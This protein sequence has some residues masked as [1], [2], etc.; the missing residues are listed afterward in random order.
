MAE[1]CAPPRAELDLLSAES[2]RTVVR[3]FQPDWILH[4][5]AYTAVDR[6]EA[7]RDACFAINSGATRTFAEEA[8]RLDATLVTFSTD[9]VFDGTAD[10]AYREDDL[11]NPINVYGASKLQAEK[12]LQDVGCRYLNFR[13]SWVYSARGTNFVKT[14]LRLASSRP[15][16]KVVADQQGCPSSAQEIARTV[17]SL[18]SKSKDELAEKSGTYHLAGTGETTWCD[19]AREVV[20]VARRLRP[21][22]AWTEPEPVPSTAY[23]TAAQRPANS[24]L[25]CLK[26]A[27]ELGLR[28]P[29]WRTSTEDVV[30]QI[31]AQ[32]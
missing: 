19:F 1:V 3:Q 10:R 30:T 24:R 15:E 25:D 9:Y 4:A 18:L 21:G 11:T 28:L 16:L 22:T 17:A 6:A 5:A 2:I 13:T 8:G 7:E 27:Q 29:A 32:G 12:A 26:A 20:A 23:V 14:M 31:L